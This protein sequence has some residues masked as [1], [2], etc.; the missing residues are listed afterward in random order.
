MR[1]VDAAEAFLPTYM[2]AHNR[3]FAQPPAAATAAWRRPP[4]D[5]ADRLSCRYTRQVPQDNTV[6]LGARL[7]QIPRGRHGR[8]YA[9]CRV[10][11]RECVDGR[12]LV[13]YQH[14]RL[15]T[16]PTPGPG[17][18]LLPR[19]ARRRRASPT[20][21][22]TG[23]RYLPLGRNQPVSPVAALTALA[24]HVRRS[25]R[26]HPWRRTFSARQRERNHQQ[27]LRGRTFSLNS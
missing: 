1:T 13:E 16:A 19:R 18:V 20:R 9:G 8:S 23:G 25:T 4:R 10:T 11:V 27:T 7:V 5:L 3:R 2:A 12:L 24:Q 26:R 17:F 14:Q 15:V 22:A 6:R 21:V